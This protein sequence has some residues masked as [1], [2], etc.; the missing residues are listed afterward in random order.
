M[1]RM[2]VLISDA[3][4]ATAKTYGEKAIA[5]GVISSTSEDMRLFY[6][7]AP[8]HTHPMWETL[9]QSGRTDFVAS[10]TLGDAMNAMGDPRVAAYFKNTNNDS[11]IGAPHG[12]QV[13][14]YDYS[15]P[16]AALEDPTWSHAA[17]DYVETE[18]LL[19]HA[20]VLGWAGAGD[21]QMH[22]ENAVTASIE[23]WGGSAADATTYLAH[24][25][26]MWDAAN[27]R[28][29]IGM[30]KWIAAYS[31]SPIAYNTVRQYDIPMQVAALAGTVT[32]NRFSY[33]LSEI[34][35]N[36]ANRDAA[37]AKFNGD[38]TFA[39]VFWDAM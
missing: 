16:G 7:S 21:A 23:E 2:A 15:Q 29:L 25:D 19:A 38:D 18:F 8:P 28:D 17:I 5:G 11:V 9:V 33:P 36:K 39:K 1:L 26:V 31:N 35:L 10:A 34:S 32:P 4:A 22:Y 13:N 12:Y 14:Y 24:A 27:A 3:D 37:A 20:A 6:A 30:Q